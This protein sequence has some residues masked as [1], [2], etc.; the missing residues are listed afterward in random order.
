MQG[1]GK[2]S[3]PDVAFDG[4]P[5]TGV[6][7]YQTSLFTGHGSWEVVGGTSLGTPAW[8]AII[9]IVDQGRVLDGK[10]SLDG[11]TQTLPTLYSLPSTDFNVIA[12][13]GSR[14]SQAAG[15]APIPST[16]QGHPERAAAGGRPGRQQHFNRF[17]NQQGP[18]RSPNAQLPQKQIRWFASRNGG[19]LQSARACCTGTGYHDAPIALVNV[20]NQRVCCKAQSHQVRF[21]RESRWHVLIGS[22]ADSTL[23]WIAHPGRWS[24]MRNRRRGPRCGPFW[25]NLTTAVCCR[26][27]RRSQPSGYTPAQITAAYG[28]N[29]I[30]FTSS[31]GSTVKGDGTGETI[32]LI[33]MY[34][35]P[36]IQS[37][38]ATFDAKYNLPD[39]D[40]HRGEPGGQPDRQRLGA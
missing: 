38:L 26:A 24:L 29:A 18:H 28:L 35:D 16:G 40:A 37:D 39:S 33:E 34:H 21:L 22:L 4:D 27:F 8:A 17:D 36:N 19:R 13:L 1:T 2:R 9:A 6:R 5:N 30:T 20:R 23:Q 14:I 10:G 32:A 7:V 3:T 25:M 12:P 15:G 11:A 31:S